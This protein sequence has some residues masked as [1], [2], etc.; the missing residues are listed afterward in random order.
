MDKNT[1]WVFG[2]SFSEDVESLPDGNGRV[3][4]VNN[5]L[6]GVPYKIWQKKVAEALGYDYQNRAALS[7][8]KFN[9]LG[10]GN[11]NDQMYL[12]I[13][14]YASQIKKGDIVLV[15]F[16][17]IHRVQVPR[18][19]GE[20]ISLTPHIV[21]KTDLPHLSDF[22][23]KRYTAN[24]IDRG[25]PY[26]VY[27]LLQRFKLVETLADKVGFSLYYWYWGSPLT[28]NAK[29]VDTSRWLNYQ[30]LGSWK[31]IGTYCAEN[32]TELHSIEVE[33][34]GNIVDG[35]WGVRGNKTVFNIFYP[36]IKD[37]TIVH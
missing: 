29:Q 13:C 16:T 20:I 28:H 30:V 23:L 1:V 3:D 12:N 34:N 27:E 24:I 5:Y 35:H 22:D 11:S 31:D 36:Y 25:N 21:N 18:E 33:T 14:E 32:N 9:Y 7:G 10:S 6:N 17:D 37:K 15:G 8:K 2:D 4:Y 26:Y 19:D